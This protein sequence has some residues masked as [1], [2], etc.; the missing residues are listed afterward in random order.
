MIVQRTDVVHG[1]L[2]VELADNTPDVRRERRLRPRTRPQVNLADGAGLIAVRK[3]TIGVRRL[4]ERVVERI[5]RHA[6]DD[7][8]PAPGFHSSSQWFA[9]IE[10]PP[11]QFF[12]DDDLWWRRAIVEIGEVRSARAT[13]FP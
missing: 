7:E 8:T 1:Q 9:V 3:Y 10:K 6:G 13:E 2:G 12:V 5:P 4:A 11:D